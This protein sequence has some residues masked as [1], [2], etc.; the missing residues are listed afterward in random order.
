MTREIA[1][2]K[3]FEAALAS[4]ENDFPPGT[5]SGDEK[6]GH[7]YVAGSGAFGESGTNGGGAAEGFDLAEAN[8]S[9]GF[10][11]DQD[12]LLRASGQEVK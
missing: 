2:Q 8:S 7:A 3:V 5:L 11:L 4:L 12:P 6:L 9:W 1:H 10:T